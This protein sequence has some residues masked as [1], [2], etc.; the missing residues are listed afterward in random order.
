[1]HYYFIGRSSCV[2]SGAWYE[3]SLSTRTL[4]IRNIPNRPVRIR[5]KVCIVF[6]ADICSHAT[7]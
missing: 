3:M 4:I 2:R 5:A 7:A 1:M 6:I